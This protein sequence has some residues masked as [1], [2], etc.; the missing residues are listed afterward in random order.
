LNVFYSKFQIW[1]P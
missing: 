1:I